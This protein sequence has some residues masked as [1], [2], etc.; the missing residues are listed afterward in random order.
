MK[1]PAVIVAGMA[2][3]SI[4]RESMLK[5]LRQLAS[6]W[7][8]LPLLERHKAFVR[9]YTKISQGIS[10]TSRN[11]CG[12]AIGVRRVGEQSYIFD[13]GKRSAVKLN[14]VVDLDWSLGSC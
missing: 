2:S 5:K 8:K 14:C 10:W 1:Y 12:H 9:E 13:T 3:S 11:L 4:V 7:S 6:A